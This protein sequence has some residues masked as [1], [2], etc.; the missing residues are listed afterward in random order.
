MPAI[1][2]PGDTTTF[3][4][5]TAMPCRLMVPEGREDEAQAVLA[6]YLSG[7]PEEDEG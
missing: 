3:L 2:R 1:I 7:A 4:G 5:V 6:L